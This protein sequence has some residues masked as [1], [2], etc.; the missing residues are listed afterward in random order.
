MNIKNYTSQ[1][2]AHESLA[3]IENMLVQIGAT[4]INKQYKDKICT[5]VTC[6]YYDHQLFQTIPFHF[7]ADTD[8]C[9]AILWKEVIRP[10]PETKQ[11]TMEQAARTAWKIVSD[12][13]E[14]QCS[15]I[16]MGQAKPLQMFLANVYDI[17][18]QETYYDKVMGGEMKLLN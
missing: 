1:I 2:K 16:L 12:L 9:F 17:K 15:M 18:K 10:R 14:L 13:I 7:T 3:K 8:A 6:L 5:G 11:N 4:D